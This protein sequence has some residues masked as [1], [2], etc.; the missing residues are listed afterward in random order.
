MRQ[1]VLTRVDRRSLLD[2]LT[3]GAGQQLRA[4]GLV[5]FAAARRSEL[6]RTVTHSLA[7]VTAIVRATGKTKKTA[8]R[9]RERFLEGRCLGNA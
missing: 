4:K 8:Y 3:T 5:S 1:L 7:G 2:L 9:W 6:G